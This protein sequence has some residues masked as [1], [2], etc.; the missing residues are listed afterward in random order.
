MEVPG[1]E[2]PAVDGELFEG[3]GAVWQLIADD[4]TANIQA[5]RDSMKNGMPDKFWEPPANFR[6]PRPEDMT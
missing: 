1:F 4:A 2:R 3:E 6:I 5:I